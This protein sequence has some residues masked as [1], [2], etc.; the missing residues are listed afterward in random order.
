[1]APPKPAEPAPAPEAELLQM[2]KNSAF[3]SILAAYNQPTRP[4]QPAVMGGP[5]QP[6]AVA[7]PVASA[8]NPFMMGNMTP[9]S[10]IAP[11]WPPAFTGAAPR[12]FN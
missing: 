6:F 5:F 4:A 1:M 11:S 12:K 3:D 8:T 7:P 10:Q 9:Q 2:N